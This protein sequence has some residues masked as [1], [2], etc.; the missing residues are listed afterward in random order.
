MGFEQLEQLPG[1]RPL[2][3]T[4]DVARAL[5]LGAAAGRIGTGCRVLAQ[6]HLGY[7]STIVL[8]NVSYG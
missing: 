7:R 4:P 1:D 5:A 3:A 8:T 6:P 2:H